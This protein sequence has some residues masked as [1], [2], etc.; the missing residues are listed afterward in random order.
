MRTWK[1]RPLLGRLTATAALAAMIGGLGLVAAAPAHAA[2]TTLKLDRVKC[3]EQTDVFFDDSPYVLV[4]ATSP[5]NSG[6]VQFGKW[7][8]GYLDN[9]VDSG[10]TYYPN[11]T[12]TGGVQPGW[13]LWTVLM[14]EDDG[15]DLSSGDLNYIESMLWNQWQAAFW[16]PA[17]TQQ[18]LMTWAFFLAIDDVT[19]NDDTVALRKFTISGSS[20]GTDVSFNGDG[21]AY[22]LRFKLV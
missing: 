6:A 8:P 5:T 20:A 16:Q 4:F 19:G 13:T 22:W 10:D 21:G 15:N 3:I 12:I 17:S 11:G 18:L 9:V 14:E 2:G 7:G 1:R